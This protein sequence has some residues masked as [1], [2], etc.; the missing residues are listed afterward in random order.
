MK[1]QLVEQGFIEVSTQS[2]AKKGDITLA[3][4]LDVAKPALRTNLT[5]NLKDVLSRAKHYIPR[6]LGPGAKLKLFEVGTVFPKAGEYLALEMSERVL[7]WGDAAGM[8]DNLSVAKLEEYGKEY[9]PILL[10]QGAYKPFSIYPFITRD[11]ALWVPVGTTVAAV[12]SVVRENAG[13]LLVRLDSFDQFEKEGR[14]SYAFR[15]VFESMERTLT[16]EDA[17][18]IMTRIS[19]VLTAKGYETR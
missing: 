15:L 12:E 4:P 2:F 18:V 8:H 17:N 19:S 1:D 3:N 11:I 13:G 10:K 14:I 16:D 9:T 5:E 6:L 7:T